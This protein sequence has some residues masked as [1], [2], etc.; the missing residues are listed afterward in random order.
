MDSW[1]KVKVERGDDGVDKHPMCE[2]CGEEFTLGTL[3]IRR[4]VGVIAWIKYKLVTFRNRIMNSRIGRGLRWFDNL[5]WLYSTVFA[6]CRT[7]AQLPTLPKL[8]MTC[9]KDPRALKPMATNLVSSLLMELSLSTYD[10]RFYLESV[11]FYAL[12]W[13]MDACARTVMREHVAGLP[14]SLQGVVGGFLI[15]PQAVGLTIQAVDLS[16]IFLLGG[17]SSSYLDGMLQVLC[18]PLQLV[19][20]LTSYA[21]VKLKAVRLG[22]LAKFSSVR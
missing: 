8:I 14:P 12:G 11:A 3:D 21:A 22:W 15:V 5:M 13:T 16:F 2:L 4:D 7:I 1:M 9:R 17:I 6:G 20:E 19:G 10:Y 18:M